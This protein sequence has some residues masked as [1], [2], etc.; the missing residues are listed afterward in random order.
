[1]KTLNIALAISSVM[2]TS[3]M[4]GRAFIFD[5]IGR[6]NG[7]ATVASSQLHP[8][9]PFLSRCATMFSSPRSGRDW[10]NDD[11]LSSLGRGGRENEGSEV[12]KGDNAPS[13]DRSPPSP[14]KHNMTDEEITEWAMRA[15]KFYNTDRK[16][17]EVYGVDR[18]RGTKHLGNKE[19][20]EED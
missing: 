2:H 12:G 4:S 16:I 20:S 10:T 18:Q 19:L 8:S 15:A 11:F 14:Q 1:M 9:S 6:R 13:G 3:D 17:E 5:S 7:P